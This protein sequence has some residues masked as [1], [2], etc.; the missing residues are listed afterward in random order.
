MLGRTG[1]YYVRCR[2]HQPS[3]AARDDAAADRLWETSER[4]VGTAEPV[5]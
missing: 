2:E 5:G 1:G 3:R 4:L